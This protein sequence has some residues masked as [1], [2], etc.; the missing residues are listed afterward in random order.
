MGDFNDNP[1]DKSISQVL[2]VY[3]SLD[4][5]ANN[6]LYDCN[7]KFNWKIGEGTEFYRGEW[8]R[9]IQIIVSTSLIKN[10][11]GSDGGFNDIHIFKPDWLLEEDK[12]YHQMTPNR[13]FDESNSAIGFSDH[14]P[15]FIVLR[16]SK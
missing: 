1:P 9:F 13:T 8:S 6:S 3:N 7:S 2:K 15:V 12:Q 4:A 11:I 14:L 10:Q 16:S 5:A